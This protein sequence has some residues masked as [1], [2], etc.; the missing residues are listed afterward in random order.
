MRAWP[1]AEPGDRTYTGPP[2]ELSDGGGGGGDDDKTS[3]ELGFMTRFA[4]VVSDL[5]APGELEVKA[6]DSRPSSAEARQEELDALE[7][8]LRDPA[9][10]RIDQS[11][12]PLETFDDV[13][14]WE[15]MRP[16]GDPSAWFVNEDGTYGTR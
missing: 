10:L 15:Q 3:D 1:F 5:G 16:R 13:E 9:F 2:S 12:L 7:L 4:P 6:S 11:A 14:T 8:M